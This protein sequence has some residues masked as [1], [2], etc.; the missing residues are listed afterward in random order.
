[1]SKIAIYAPIK[2]P[3]H[4]IASGDRLV[5]KNL[6]KALT[7]AGHEVKLASRF[8][9]Y[10]KREADEILKQKKQD[11]LIE[12]NTILKNL[13]T[14]PP[15]L[16]LTYHP[17]CKAP[18]WIGPIIS[19]ALSIPYLTV[20]AARTGQ[21]FEDGNDRW[22]RW[23]DEAQIGIRKADHHIAFKHTDRAYL[24]G[25]L[26]STKNITNIPPFIDTALP[27][28]LPSI[29]HPPHWRPGAP[30][31]VTAGMMRPGKK[32][33]NF[34]LL[35]KALEPLQS[36]HW[37]LVLIGGGPEEE[38]VHEFFGS[39][40]PARL[41]FTGAISH[42]DVL[43]HMA[44]AD[45]FVWPGWKEPIGM[46]YME[47]QLMGLPVAALRSMG[48]PLTVYHGE[49]GLLAEENNA[50]GFRENLM[51]LISHP[52]LRKDLGQTAK[53]SIQTRHSLHAGAKALQKVLA[54]FL[55]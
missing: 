43:A 27:E 40:D 54:P 52:S 30:V 32:V 5:A 14:N 31:L 29:N 44:G 37:N 9:A 7:I 53:T 2:P 1:M 3:D 49:T 39:I 36:L 17:Y 4:P 33:K 45:L 34:E 12:A 41:H 55:P 6:I 11:A 22:A 46:V 21:G 10:S 26:G 16:W 28:S 13:R 51:S 35:A 19:K 47:A 42:N 48:V 15:D 24:K 18:D 20:E 23:R 38:T 50:A 25:L 8:I